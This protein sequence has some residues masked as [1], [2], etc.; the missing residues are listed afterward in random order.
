MLISLRKLTSNCY[1]RSRSFEPLIDALPA[2]RG[3]R[4]RPKRWPGKLRADKGYDFSRCHAHLKQLGIKDRIAPRGIERNDR[5]GRPRWVVERTH[6]W[7][8]AFG[9]LRTLFER[10]IETHVALLSLACFVICVRHIMPF[11]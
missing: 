7:L 2:I 11:C 3:K 5:L 9:K 6:G 8:A 1:Q 4:G 10:R